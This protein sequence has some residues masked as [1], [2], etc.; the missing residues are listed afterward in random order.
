MRTLKKRLLILIFLSYLPPLLAEDISDSYKISP[1]DYTR[2]SIASNVRDTWKQNNITN[3][4]YTII[5]KCLCDLVKRAQI[6]VVNNEIVKILD[7]D[8]GNSP[9]DKSYFDK[10]KTIDEHIAFIHRTLK[11][12]ID[13]VYIDHDRY[14]G[15][16]SK[17]FIDPNKRLADDETNISISHLNLLIENSPPANTNSPNQ[18]Q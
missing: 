8:K 11:K 5:N 15:F 12:P 10:Y 16:P 7:L 2:I 1:I 14:L 13:K 6:F 9:L 3:Y 18:N 4:V 17:I